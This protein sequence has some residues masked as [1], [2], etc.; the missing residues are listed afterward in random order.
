M[1]GREEMM[2]L[3]IKQAGRVEWGLSR[4]LEGK[5]RT[6]NVDVLVEV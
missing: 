5:V 6:P 2:S 4:L 3:S 1:R